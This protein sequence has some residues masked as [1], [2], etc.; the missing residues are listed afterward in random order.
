MEC[1]YEQY[2]LETS[3]LRIPEVITKKIDLQFNEVSPLLFIS[4]KLGLLTLIERFHF[5][6]EN[7][8]M[9]EDD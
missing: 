3:V 8:E 1:F 2:F 4:L 7:E 6:I 5:E 9:S